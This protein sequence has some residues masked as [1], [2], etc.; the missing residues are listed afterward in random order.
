MTVGVSRKSHMLSYSCSWSTTWQ[1]RISAYHLSDRFCRGLAWSVF[2]GY[3]MIEKFMYKSTFKMFYHQVLCVLN[4]FFLPFLTWLCWHHQ[5]PVETQTTLGYLHN[6]GSL[7]TW[8]SECLN[9]N[10]VNHVTRWK[11]S[12]IENIIPSSAMLIVFSFVCLGFFFLKLTPLLWQRSY[13]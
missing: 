4:N 3:A 11:S 2:I 5:P 6:P 10:Q 1:I 13:G 7:I 12:Q 8:V 9:E